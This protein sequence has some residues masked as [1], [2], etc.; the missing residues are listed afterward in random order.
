MHTQKFTT[1]ESF[2]EVIAR[3]ILNATRFFLHL[4]YLKTSSKMQIPDIVP[5]SSLP[6]LPFFCSIIM[7]LKDSIQLLWTSDKASGIGT[8]PLMW[9]CQC[10]WSSHPNSSPRSVLSGVLSHSLSLDLTQQVLHTSSPSPAGQLLP[11]LISIWILAP[12]SPLALL[13]IS[14]TFSVLTHISLSLYFS[15]I[16]LNH[17]PMSSQSQP[18]FIFFF[19]LDYL[20]LLS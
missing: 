19:L 4:L 5:L 13:I 8:L 20:Q 6:A 9:S 18:Y 2:L 17:L 10:V 14:V 11:L 15:V 12:G 3:N 1:T 7:I 16:Y